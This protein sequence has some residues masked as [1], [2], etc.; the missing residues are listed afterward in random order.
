MIPAGEY[1]VLRPADL[2]LTLDAARGGEL[3]LSATAE[4]TG[5]PARFADHASWHAIGHGMSTGRWPNG[6]P[7]GPIVPMLH[8]TLPGA[9]AGPVPGEVII[10]EIHFV[11]KLP[12]FQE[13]FEQGEATGF[14]PVLGHWSVEEGRYAL[15]PGPEQDSMAII[16]GINALSSHFTLAATLRTPS[17]S[18]FN[19]NGMLIFDYRGPLDFKFASIHSAGNRWRI[20]HRDETGWNFLADVFG[21]PPI[22]SD[23]DYDLTV[24]ISGTIAR[25]RSGSSVKAVH[26]FA[27]PL[28]NGQVGLGSKNGHALFDNV[29]IQPLRA[30]EFEFVELVNTTTRAIDLGAWELAGPV[31]WTFPEGSALEAGAVVTLVG[32][33]P[34]DASR[35][36]PFRRLHGIQAETIL[37]GP[38]QGQLGNQRGVIQLLKPLDPDTAE[39]GMALADMAR[40]DRLAPWPAAAS[41]QGMSLQRSAAEA[42]GHFSASWIA[43]IPTPGTARYTAPADMDRNGAI[44]D[45]DLEELAAALLDPRAFQENFGLAALL[46]GDVDHDGD[47]DFD[48]IDD[49]LIFVMGFHGA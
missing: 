25:L 9:N 46:A 26:D 49:F 44:D 43:A 21:F 10:S 33:D 12:A 1:L 36:D 38:Y 5:K 32:F 28:S 27:V 11:P 17:G 31:Q 45:A 16:P 7:L 39:S 8:P 34:G 40:Y 22:E 13:D 48:D 2:G 30:A 23:T 41:D 19:E 47:L 42:F 4:N 3:W 35:A 37:M 20:G 24:E 29:S 18:D 6:D 15:R 14:T